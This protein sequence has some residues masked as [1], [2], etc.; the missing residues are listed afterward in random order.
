ME[1]KKLFICIKSEEYIF[2]VLCIIGAFVSSTMSTNL[3]LNP[4]SESLGTPEAVN[5]IECLNA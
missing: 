3:V 2:L 4:F 5:E 1:A